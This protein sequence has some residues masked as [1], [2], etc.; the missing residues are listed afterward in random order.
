LAPKKTVSSARNEPK[1]AW[2]RAAIVAANAVSAART[3]ATSSSRVAMGTA[4]TGVAHIMIAAAAAR[5]FRNSFLLIAM[6]PSVLQ[7]LRGMFQAA[8]AA[9]S[10]N[11]VFRL[12]VVMSSPISFETS[13]NSLSVSTPP[14]HHS[15]AAC[16]PIVNE[17]GDQSRAASGFSFARAPGT[18]GKAASRR[19]PS[20][21]RR[22]RRRLV[23]DGVERRRADHRHA[24]PQ[25]QRRGQFLFQTRGGDF[26]FQFPRRGEHDIAARQHGG[27][28]REAAGRHGRAQVSHGHAI[29]APD[30]HPAQQGHT[31]LRHASPRN[32]TQSS[33]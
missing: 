31:T 12:R 2:S 6:L 32:Q 16:A 28:V 1:A 4:T 21:A 23:D 15:Q 30:V 11:S 33:P 19:E 29:A 25:R 3:C 14:G 5:P 27:H 22:Q 26:G 17:A 24:H 18:R 7:A 8:N 20:A 10:F 9:C 13:S